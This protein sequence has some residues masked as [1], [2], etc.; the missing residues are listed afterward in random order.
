[1]ARRFHP[2][3]GSNPADIARRTAI[4]AEIN[5]A[6]EEENVE[7]LRAFWAAV[8]PDEAQ[9]QQADR[10]GRELQAK[11][12]RIVLNSLRRRIFALKQNIH[13]LEQSDLMRLKHE[14]HFY[15]LQGRDL[16][17]EMADGFRAEYQ[18]CLRKLYRLR[19]EANRA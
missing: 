11:Q 8:E 3:F 4:M 7:V 5:A 9:R 6:Y 13:D 2:D 18:D 19:Q 14:V 12:L 17:A 1:L 16:L 15:R 10:A